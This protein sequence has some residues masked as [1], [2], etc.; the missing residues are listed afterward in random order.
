[1][2]VQYTVKPFNFIVPSHID[3][4]D[5]GGSDGDVEKHTKHI[6]FFSLRFGFFTG[7]GAENKEHFFRHLP[8]LRISVFFR[9]SCSVRIEEIQLFNMVED[10]K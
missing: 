10:E 8:F 6:F 3:D 9:F 2:N 7:L 4:D 1:M 5:G